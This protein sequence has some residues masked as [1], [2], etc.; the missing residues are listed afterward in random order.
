MAKIISKRAR[1]YTVTLY[2]YISTAEGVMTFQRTVIERVYLD[3]A[4]QQH[5]SQRGIA[6]SDTCQLII[7][8][9][10]ITATGG[11]T[12]IA[13]KA[14]K[15]L[16]A[17]EKADYFTFNTANDFF[18][19]GEATETLPSKTKKEMIELY[20]CFAVSSVNI[21]A[22]DQGRALIVEVTGK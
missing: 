12:F 15:K 13:T 17:A 20:Q 10:D 9:R 1:P 5:L 18:V 11:R 3:T 16:T 19:E 22:C 2:N 21:P 8:L 14:W 7:D 6:T 4:Y